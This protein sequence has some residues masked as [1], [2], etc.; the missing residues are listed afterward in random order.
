[1]TADLRQFVEG[2]LLVLAALLP[3]VNPLGSAPVFLA[4]TAGTDDAT[5]GLLARK[6]A[7]NGFILLMASIFVGGFVLQFFGLSVPVV[8]IAGGLL[9]CSLAWHLL[10]EG[11]PLPDA[12]PAAPRSGDSIGTRAF[13]PLTLP[14]TVGP[15][16]ISVAITL[17][18]NHPTTMRSYVV[19]AIT[20]L[21]GVVIVCAAI[22]AC[23]KYSRRLGQWLGPTGTAVFLR[24]SAFILLCIGVQ[25]M[26]NGIDALLGISSAPRADLR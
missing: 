9:V 5:R 26:W 22:F 13:Y 10:K 24:L 1:M 14:L 18:A 12:T 25:I 8:Q 19:A 17:G 21:I 23:F 3:I 16:S 7:V 2:V 6:I 11:E 20:S 4:M 15:G